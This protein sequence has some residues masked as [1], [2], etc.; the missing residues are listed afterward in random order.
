MKNGKGLI[1]EL[2]EHRV[3][4]LFQ[5]RA[6]CIE[7]EE[8]VGAQRCRIHV[9]VE[10][11]SHRMLRFRHLHTRRVGIEAISLRARREAIGRLD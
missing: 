10:I 9:R 5:A 8:D 1:A 2:V 3:A 7:I 4:V 11:A 6:G